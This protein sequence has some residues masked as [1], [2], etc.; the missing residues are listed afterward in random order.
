MVVPATESSDSGTNI[1]AANGGYVNGNES[2]KKK[3]YSGSGLR[4]VISLPLA[5]QPA[6]G[7]G[8]IRYARLASLGVK[9][10]KRSP[11]A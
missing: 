11:A 4:A 10:N 5:E 1:S 3:E 8:A 6:D 2:N 9:L 7:M